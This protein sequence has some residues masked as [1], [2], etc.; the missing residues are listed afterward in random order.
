MGGQKGGNN[1][2]VKENKSKFIKRK[3]NS[4]LKK[5]I[6]ELKQEVIQGEI[7]NGVKQIP[8]TLSTSLET[9]SES[10]VQTLVNHQ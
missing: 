8:V 4:K 6:E 2:H 3:A 9:N 7:H 10:V 5:E 1:W